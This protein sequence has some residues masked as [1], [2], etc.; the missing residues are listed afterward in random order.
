MSSDKRKRFHRACALLREVNR[1]SGDEGCVG[2][3]GR[4]LFSTKN[5][6][7]RY[8]LERGMARMERRHRG[9]ITRRTYFV[10]NLEH[11]L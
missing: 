4:G 11:E 9:G 2:Q 10:V 1:I 3:S 6:V 7:V 5:P 8:C